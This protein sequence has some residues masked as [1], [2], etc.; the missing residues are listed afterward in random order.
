M[1]AEL[2]FFGTVLTVDDDRPTAEA[3]AVA[4]GRIVAVG[5]C[6]DVAGWIGPGTETI[7]LGNGCVMPG[8]VEAHGHP[9]MEAIV[10]S[11]RMVD[12][13][14][15]TMRDPDQIVEAIR[16]EV[17]K[18]GADGA[19]L[20]GWDPLL[21][22]GVPEPTLAWLN[23]E[24]PDTPLVIVHNSGHK[25]YFNSAAAQRA[26][27]TRDTPDPKGAKYGRDDNGDLDGTAEETGAVFSVLG[28]AIKPSDYPAMLHAEL[29]RLNRVG[30]TTCS[31]MAFEPAFRPVLEQM[32]GDLTVR[33][34]VYEVSN[35]EMT[36]DMT[37]VNGD[38]LFRQVGIK[39]W[40]DG[41]PWIGNIDLSFPYLDTDAT[42]T[43]GVPPGSC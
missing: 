26:G 14:P 8:L 31:E 13:R 35:A 1:P 3:L 4:D 42:R 43:I 16:N 19:Y 29:G 11:D 39:I 33:L 30:L 22:S 2:V 40:V 28:G 17:T 36:T 27:V 34:R 5:D 21:Q 24:A 38:D 41:S 25:A 20:N 23:G 9:M 7:E 37:P 18:R 6:A 12:I 15:V 10:L 32:R